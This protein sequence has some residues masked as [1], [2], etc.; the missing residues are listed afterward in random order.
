MSIELELLPSPAASLEVQRKAQTVVRDVANAF[1]ARLAYTPPYPLKLQFIED[2]ERPNDYLEHIMVLSLYR[3]DISVGGRTH[4]VEP[5][6]FDKTVIAHEFAHFVFWDLLAN[7]GVSEVSAKAR[8]PGGLNTEFH[9]VQEG[10]CDYMSAVTTEMPAIGAEAFTPPLR[11]LTDWD[12]KAHAKGA[13]PQFMGWGPFLWW[14]HTHVDV[15]GVALGKVV[16]ESI[17]YLRRGDGLDAAVGSLQ[18][19]CEGLYDAVACARLQNFVQ[20]AYSERFIPA[21]KG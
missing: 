12:F 21:F 4:H 15:S 2:L 7:E 5:W 18:R 16:L 19:G 17:K 9:M 13:S 10:F 20:T 14:L 8:V 11:D 1:A 6:A 3:G